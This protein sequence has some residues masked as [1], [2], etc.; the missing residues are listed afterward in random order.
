MEV[1]KSRAYR[2]KRPFTALDRPLPLLKDLPGTSDFPVTTA[3]AVAEEPEP[4]LPEEKPLCCAQCLAPVTRDRDRR[5]VGGA[6]R[7]VFANPHGFVFEIGCF[8]QAPG[9]AVMG[10]GTPDF[11][12]FPGTI[13]QVALCARC[14]V[15]LGWRY[16]G[17]PDG[18]FYGLILSRLIAAPDS[19]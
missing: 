1:C 7:H 19:V 14:G 11:S 12:W 17:H 8:S 9:C 18:P 2:T 10:P 3:P 4:A 5:P 16:E 13:W 15:H 6:H